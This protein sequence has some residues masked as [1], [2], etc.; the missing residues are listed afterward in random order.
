M[1]FQ[2]RLT[3]KALVLDGSREGE[4]GLE[5]VRQVMTEELRAL[6][7]DVEVL[8]LRTIEMKP[9]TGCFGCWTKT[10]GICVIKD[11]AHDVTRKM[12]QADLLVIL[13][14]VTFGGFSSEFKNALDRSLGLM[15]PYF[16]KIDGY[17]HHKTRY[18]RYPS[19]LVMGSVPLPDPEL[20]AI[21]RDLVARNVING[22][23]PNHSVEVVTEGQ[24]IEEIR[25]LARTSLKRTGV[26]G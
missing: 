7:W 1:H 10:P 14:P 2:N 18:K 3:M 6:D 5:P 13:T 25:V 21:F 17:V 11:D 12:I 22:H 19:W 16:T 4:E 23:A 20:E 24:D 26:T 9:C 15:L 8:Q